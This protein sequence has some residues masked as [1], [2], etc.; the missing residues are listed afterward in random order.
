MLIVYSY[1]IVIKS[2]LVIHV[3]NVCAVSLILFW[4]LLVCHTSQVGTFIITALRASNLLH[5]T[6][7][8]FH[9]F[10]IHPY[11]NLYLQPQM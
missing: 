11:N 9:V 3:V 7:S 5:I 4:T 8:S 1:D 6:L 10:F 2:Y